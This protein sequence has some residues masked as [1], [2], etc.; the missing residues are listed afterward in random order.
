MSHGQKEHIASITQEAT[1]GTHVWLVLTKAY[2]SLLRHAE[3]SFAAEDIGLRDFV[4]LEVLVN[5]GPQ[6]VSEIGRKE[7]LSSGA[8]TT[9]VDR[10][11]KQGLVVRAFDL[12]DRRGARSFAYADGGEIDFQSLQEACAGDG[13]GD[14]RP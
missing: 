9:A 2:P 4:V 5:K 6:K 3:R 12:N 11:E 13:K 14:R 7:G 1:S 8:I 10:V